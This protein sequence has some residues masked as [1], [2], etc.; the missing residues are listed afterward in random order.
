MNWLER[1]RGVHWDPPW[2][3][4]WLFVL[5]AIGALVYA[6]YVYRRNEAPLR[7]GFRALLTLLRGLA[8]ALLVVILCRPVLSMAV[9]GGAARGVLVLLDR[10]E[11]LTLPAVDPEQT[12]DDELR[13][14]VEGIQEGLTGSY[15]LPFGASPRTSGR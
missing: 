14:A 4:G 5:V 13:R 2:D 8:L 9:P 12:R 10:S 6:A 15:P 3:A 11:S 7:P 1:W